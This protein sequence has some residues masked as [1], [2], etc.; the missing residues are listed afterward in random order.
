MSI[1][2]LTQTI[3][4]LPAGHSLQSNRALQPML[5]GLEPEEE[6]RPM[7]T[8]RQ[9]AERL[10]LSPKTA[11]HHVRSVL[12]KLDLS[13]RAEAAAYAVRHPGTNS[14]TN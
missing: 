12:A 7:V 8:N 9:I 3:H 10:F 1:M 2:Q 11:E 5:P 13:N 4:I 6:T 14:A